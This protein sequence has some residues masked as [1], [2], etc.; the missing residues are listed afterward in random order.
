MKLLQPLFALF[1]SASDRDLVRMI[2]YLKAENRILRDK[3]PARITVTPRERSRLL[4]LGQKV[5]SSLRDLITIV[6]YRT[7]SRWLAAAKGKPKTKKSSR[8]PGQPRTA[9][10][11]CRLVLRIA[12]ETGWGYTRILGELK[13]LGIRSVSRST[14]V[15]ILKD[16]GLDPGP[17]RGTGSWDEFLMRHA[18]TLWACDFLS[19]K[20]ATLHGVVD[21]YILFFIHVGSRRA[22]VAGITP[23]PTGE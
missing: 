13:K 22:F 20:S 8:K 23:N 1:A 18:E 5:G 9:E 17:N 12:R 15:N 21:L 6:S 19:V 7:F 2:E 14:V 16:A 3:L 11:L 10:A 4:R